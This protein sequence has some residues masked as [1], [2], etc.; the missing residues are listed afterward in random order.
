MKNFYS[1][2]SVMA[3]GCVPAHAIY[4]SIY[5]Q[6]KKHLNCEGPQNHYKFAL[7]GIASS[8]FHDLVMTPTEVI[9]QRLQLL[10]S[11]GTSISTQKLV[12]K[13]YKNEGVVSFYRSFFV[14]YLMNVPFGSMVIF[15]NEKIKYL[16]NI[17]EQDS[18][19]KYFICAGLAGGLASIPTCPFDVIKTRLNT[20]SCLNNNCEKKQVCQMLKKTKS[21]PSM[22]IKMTNEMETRIKMSISS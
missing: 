2:L 4:F 22:K 21:E 3:M 5:E 11:Q 6:S 17:K 9:K 7:V 19:F 14:N 1:G 18:Y 15:F 20:Q 10:R 12:S 16:M 13:M 8:L